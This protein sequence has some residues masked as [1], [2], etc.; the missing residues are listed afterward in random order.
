MII[1]PTVF[2]QFTSKTPEDAFQFED[3]SCTTWINID[4]LNQTETI[5]KVGKYYD[6]H[7][8]IIEDIA[9]TNQR[10]KIDEYKDYLFIV[11]KMLYLGPGHVPEPTM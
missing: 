9:N 3:E 10:P 5:E 8:L 7:P 4:G 11:A 6:L 1:T 2:E